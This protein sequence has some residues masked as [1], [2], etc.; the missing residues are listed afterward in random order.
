MK[1]YYTTIEQSKKLFNAGLDPNTAD[2][3]WGID[4]ETLQYNCT[5]YPLPWRGYTAK[6]FYMPCWSIGALL[7]IVPQ[8]LM[9]NRY[10]FVVEKVQGSNYL[11]GYYDTK[12]ES[13]EDIDYYISFC[14]KSLVDILCMLI[15]YMLDVNKRKERHQDMVDSFAIGIEL[16]KQQKS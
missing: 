7:E 12:S 16:L 13:C 15:L 10:I 5:P 9:N 1:N 6:Q 14:G 2:M 3:C 8:S 11:V 4:D